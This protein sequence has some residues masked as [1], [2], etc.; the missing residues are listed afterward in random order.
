MHFPLFQ[1]YETKRPG[2][3]RDI[4]EP[5]MGQLSIYFITGFLLTWSAIYPLLWKAW[6]TD[7][8]RSKFSVLWN[9]K[10]VL[11]KKHLKSHAEPYYSYIQYRPRYRWTE[12]KWTLKKEDM[13]LR[14]DLSRSGEGLLHL[15]DHRF[16]S[17]LLG[18]PPWP[19]YAVNCLLL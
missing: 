8:D 1:P 11:F 14:L 9:N 10:K 7:K 12:I 18:A 19:S 6:G 3:S 2:T 16:V 13:K 15:Q 17:L 5:N 4:N